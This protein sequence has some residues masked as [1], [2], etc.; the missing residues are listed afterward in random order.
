M[1]VLFVMGCVGSASFGYW[2]GYFREARRTAFWRTAY[3]RLVGSMTADSVTRHN[4]MRAGE[5]G[6]EP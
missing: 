3:S 4:V 6:R 1:M 2:V 5:I